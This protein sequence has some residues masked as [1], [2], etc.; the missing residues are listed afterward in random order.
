M[1]VID[2]FGRSLIF[3]MKHLSIY[4]KGRART[5]R[6]GYHPS[7]LICRKCKDKCAIWVIAKEALKM[8]GDVRFI[9]KLVD[10][11]H[12]NSY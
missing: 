7:M 10:M 9:V 1:I 12:A 8:I 11:P 3:D 2:Y 6:P 4:C 5:Y